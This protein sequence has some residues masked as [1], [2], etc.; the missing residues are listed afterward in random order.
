M[1]NRKY[2]LPMNFLQIDKQV[3]KSMTLSLLLIF[4]LTATAQPINRIAE[5]SIDAAI[6]DVALV[7]KDN[8]PQTVKL[9][10]IGDVASFAREITTFNTALAAFLISR[11]NVRHIIL[12]HTNWVIR[13][14]ND[15]IIGK[16]GL[17]TLAIDSLVRLSFASSVYLTREFRL[18]MTWLKKYNLSNPNKVVSLSGSGGPEALIPVSYFLSAYVFPVDRKQGVTLAK[19]WAETGYADSLAFKD[20]EMWY[21]GKQKDA[22]LLNKHKELMARCGEDIAYNKS[23]LNVSSI[24]ET[25]AMISNVILNKL[26]EGND[27]AIFLAGNELITKSKIVLNNVTVSSPGLLLQ[28]KIKDG[29]YACVTD[30]SDTATVNVFDPG[31]NDFRKDKVPGSRQVK[32]LSV[33]KHYYFMP[34]DSLYLHHYVTRTLLPLPGLIRTVMPGNTGTAPVDALFIFPELTSAT[35]LRSKR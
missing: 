3:K 2:Q 7:M 26:K 18:F 28:D 10:G 14:L 1:L 21:R 5:K 23:V 8:I 6:A 24:Q 12:F 35:I 29:Y 15:Y 19:K 4:F 30:F 22:P 27:P 17:D 34:A 32:E 13:P 9:I 16:S 33:N 25:M 11:K 31:G 20:I